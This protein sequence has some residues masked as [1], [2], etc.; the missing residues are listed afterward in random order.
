LGRGEEGK[1]GERDRIWGE[2]NWDFRI[3]LEACPVDA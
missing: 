2:R 1:L 3:K